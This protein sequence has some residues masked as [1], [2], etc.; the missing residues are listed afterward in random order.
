MLRGRALRSLR[1]LEINLGIGIQRERAMK[2]FALRAAFS[3]KL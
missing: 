1:K 3:N 2:V